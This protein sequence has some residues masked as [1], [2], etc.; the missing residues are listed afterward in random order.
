LRTVQ[1]ALEALQTTCLQRWA[2]AALTAPLNRLRQ[3]WQEFTSDAA[4][5]PEEEWQRL[6]GGESRDVSPWVVGFVL[7]VAAVL[8]V[9][10]CPADATPHRTTDALMEHLRKA[11]CDAS[12]HA[13]SLLLSE[14]TTSSGLDQIAA[15]A[16]RQWHLDVS[17]W[18]LIWDHTSALD[19]VVRRIEALVGEP[20]RS[21][22]RQRAAQFYTRIGE[23]SQVFLESLL[24]PRPSDGMDLADSDESEA[25]VFRLPLASSRRFALLPVPVDHRPTAWATEV[26]KEETRP[27]EP[28][29]RSGGFG[30]LS[31]MLK[32]TKK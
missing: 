23:R 18:V 9:N 21:E 20:Q 16:L 2:R 27:N 26:R 19:D 1:R 5:L 15:T 29:T 7:D 6:L 31:S 4:M 25:V 3:P 24:G 8:N 13:V 10:V 28:A 32:T 22:G 11:L 14:L 12:L 30:F 17:W